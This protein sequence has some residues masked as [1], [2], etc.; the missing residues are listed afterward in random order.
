MNPIDGAGKLKLSKA[1]W[2]VTRNIQGDVTL[3][4]ETL[5]YTLSYE[6]IGN[7]VLDALVVQ[8]SVPEFSQMVA[9]SQQCGVTPP[10]LTLCSPIAG[11]L[12]LEWV[13]TGKLLPGSQGQVFYEVLVE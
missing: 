13:F 3:P 2:N 1:V 11:G 5:R 4:G 10:E 8:D 9:G 12:N 6:N 7:G